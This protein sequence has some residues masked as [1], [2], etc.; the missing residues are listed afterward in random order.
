MHQHLLLKRLEDIELLWSVILKQINF[1]YCIICYF[2]WENS[3]WQGYS[4]LFDRITPKKVNLFEFTLTGYSNCC[5]VHLS[6]YWAKHDCSGAF[7]PPWTVFEP[8]RW[9]PKMLGVHNI[10]LKIIKKQK[11]PQSKER[12]VISY[13]KPK[14]YPTGGKLL[15]EFKVCYFRWLQFR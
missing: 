11:A 9:I 1:Y 5:K 10:L 4:L 7:S 2:L 12:D 13:L 6:D 15:L 14:N 3:S 8:S